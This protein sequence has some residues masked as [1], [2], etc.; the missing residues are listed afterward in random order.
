MEGRREQALRG[1]GLHDLPDV[2]HIHAV[3]DVEDHREVVGDE[4][5]RE[6]ELPL[7]VFQEIQDLGLDA[8][9]ERGRG[10]VE[11]DELRVQREGPGDPDPLPLP[12]AE[13]VR[14][15]VQVLGVQADPRQEGRHPGADLAARQPPSG[16]HEWAAAN[17]ARPRRGPGIHVAGGHLDRLRLHDR[18]RP[19][20]RAEPPLDRVHAE[21]LPHDVLHEHSRVHRGERI[22]EDD[23]HPLPESPERFRPELR[24]I[25]SALRDPAVGRVRAGRRMGGRGAE[26][27]LHRGPGQICEEGDVEDRGHDSAGKRE[28]VH[29]EEQ[30]H[31]EDRQDAGPLPEGPQAP[32]QEDA[33]GAADR[34][35]AAKPRRVPQKDSER[36]QE[37]DRKEGGGGQEDPACYEAPDASDEHD[38]REEGETEGAHPFS[39]GTEQLDLL[40]LQRWE[41][42]V[43]GPR[44]RLRE[45]EDRSPRGRLPAPALPDEPHGLP[46]RDL[47]INPVHRAD[48][49]DFPT[50]EAPADR[51]VLPEAPDLDE[52][53]SHGTR[54]PARP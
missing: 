12:A 16:P 36:P 11:D 17:L 47:Q 2:H 31:R 33:Q 15:P 6:P 40:G 9:V 52:R 37:P 43:D 54:P 4:Q 10:L 21:R 46:A 34:G 13:L 28:E 3:A 30:G 5:V 18:A 27:R 7:E 41:A 23:L 42:I 45:T 26:R 53:V 49:A 32:R 51:E 48:G 19:A 24:D 20:P 39:D 38:H 25:D 14:E 50:E 1:R 8:H 35:V 44:G 22:L 29:E